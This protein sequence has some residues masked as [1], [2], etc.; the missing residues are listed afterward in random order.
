VNALE[1]R[2]HPETVLNDWT[3]IWLRDDKKAGYVGVTHNFKSYKWYGLK[4][5]QA[6]KSHT[7][8]QLDQYITLNAYEG[9]HRDSEHL[10]Q[11]RT[12]GVDLD[13]YNVDLSILE[14]QEI[15]FD[16]VKE[17]IIPAPNLVITSRGTQLFY[18]I[19]KGA[20]PD[21]AWLTS[22]ITKQFIDK[23]KEIGADS[24][25]SD[26]SRIMRVPE[27]V[28][29]RNGATVTPRIWRNTPYTLQE[30]QAYC[31]P[32]ERF[33]NSYKRRF[34]KVYS[35][36]SRLIAINRVNH[37][38]LLDFEK[39][40]ELRNGDF[41]GKRNELLYMYSFHDAFNHDS[42]NA[43]LD[44]MRER[45]KDVFSRSDGVMDEN[46]FRRTVKS[47]YDDARTFF[48]QYKGNGY[49][50]TVKLNDGVIKPRKTSNI[51]QMLDISKDEQMHLRTLISAEIKRQRERVRKTKANR[52]K[53]IRPMTEYNEQ[54]K[55][56]QAERIEQL[57]KLMAEHPGATQREYADMLGVTAMTVSRL[58]KAI[59]R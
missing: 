46:E 43:T 52:A 10:K 27:S 3:D 18:D 44:E 19:A 9:F 32:L 4:D 45:F 54:R 34:N 26:T 49:R 48:E 24:N 38:R 5:K 25:A 20:S 47:G 14:A 23:L 51:I 21:M 40:I 37:A 57:T 8:G 30:L 33:R 16:M 15:I 53:G 58:K 55:A 42:Y 22:Y 31:K 1:Q 41:T 12:I 11:I 36:D 28:N 39:L 7:K 2:T 50:M 17:N 35:I 59:E 6:I 56:S 13:H 29:S